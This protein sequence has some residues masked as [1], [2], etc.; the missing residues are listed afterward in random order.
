ML[1][2]HEFDECRFDVA[3]NDNLWYLRASS[4]EER[5]RWMEYLEMHKVCTLLLFLIPI[6]SLC[7]DIYMITLMYTA[8]FNIIVISAVTFGFEE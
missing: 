3:V 8:M 1:Q 6:T 2:P 4:S 7:S 5:R